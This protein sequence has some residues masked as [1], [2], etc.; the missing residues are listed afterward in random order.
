MKFLIFNLVVAAALVFLFTGEDGQ[1]GNV[2]QKADKK[3]AEIKRG[4]TNLLVQNADDVSPAKKTS[5]HGATG[6]NLVKP[7]TVKAPKPKEIV[8]TPPPPVSKNTAPSLTQ[9]S[10]RSPDLSL[11]KEVVKRRNAVLAENEGVKTKEQGNSF[12][13]PRIRKRELLTLAEEMEMLAIK[14]SNE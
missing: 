13:T 1:I 10:P 8:K 6:Q 11:P 7:A 3:I 5:E 2:S 14:L 4:V 12:M 9:K